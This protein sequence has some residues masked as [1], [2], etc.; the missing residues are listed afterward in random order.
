MEHQIIKKALKI[1]ISNILLLILLGSFSGCYYDKE[2]ELYPGSQTC[3]TSA[4]TFGSSVQPIIQ[5]R[6]VSCHSGTFPS[7]GIDLSTYQNINIYAQNGS[8]V[9]VI[10]HQ[11]GFS[12]MPQGTPKMLQCEI[13][14]IKTW[15]NSGSPNN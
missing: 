10:D 15:V 4:V 2:E 7:A 1:L 9:G 6:C 12:P 13:D 3:D 11:S 14:K 5:N 8:L